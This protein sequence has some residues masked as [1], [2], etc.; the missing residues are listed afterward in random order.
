[1]RNTILKCTVSAGLLILSSCNDS[2]LNI[3]HDVSIQNPS[4]LMDYQALLD[5]AGKMN[6]GSPGVLG[7][8]GSDDFI[9]SNDNAWISYGTISAY[10]QRAYVWD[11]MIFDTDDVDLDWNS[12]YSR[13]MT[14][15]MV[16]DG[17]DKMPVA[18]RD[19]KEGR[20]VAS[21][22]KF[23]R[24]LTYF[25]LAQIYCPYYEKD[26]S[27]GQ[28]LGLPL[29][30]EAD[31]TIPSTR[32]SLK[33]TYAFMLSDLQDCIGNLPAEASS[34]FRPDEQALYALMARVF[35]QIKDYPN[36]YEYADR[37]LA[38][39]VE[40]LDFNTVDAGKVYPFPMDYGTTNGE[41]LFFSS[42]FMVTMLN[43]A[44]MQVSPELLALYGEGDLR[45]EVFY[46][47]GTAGNLYFRG[48][49]YGELPFFVGLGAAE[50]YL[51][52]AECLARDREYSQALELLDELRRYR[53]KEEEFIE[54]AMPNGDVL[55][56]VLDERRREMAFK[57]LR[58]SDL[59]RLNT[60]SQWTKQ[61]VRT[62][63][64]EN[65]ILEPNSNKYTWPIP[66]NV[67]DMTGMAQNPR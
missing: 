9:V 16:L 8:L 20:T 21:A 59:R 33:E 44:R 17:L 47:Q 22:A 63:G 3:R 62:I 5:G 42:S 12:A 67:I 52:K 65:Y 46:T 29:R 6:L 64:A 28:G 39:G 61:I 51:V 32:S 23:Y 53:F 48:S 18:E 45:K 19:S 24:A 4:T 36:A 35:L 34:K 30:K 31:V 54:L 55:R 27:D 38:M 41:V 25:Q 15:N 7:H 49:Y 14:A 58:W 10:Q 2:F 26:A 43:R 1:M 56:Y 57:G 11:D 50:L 60:E 37:A 13:I 66:Q 40:L